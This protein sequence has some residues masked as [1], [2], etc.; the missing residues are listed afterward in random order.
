MAEIL[1][2]SSSGPC[3]VESPIIHSYYNLLILVI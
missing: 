2:K 1:F 3:D